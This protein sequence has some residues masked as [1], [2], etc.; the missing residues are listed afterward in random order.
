MIG[1][2]GN[3]LLVKINWSDHVQKTSNSP[4]PN[5][6]V[7]YFQIKLDDKLGLYGK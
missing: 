5:P 4:N 1:M 6:Y 3:H 7:S 2:L